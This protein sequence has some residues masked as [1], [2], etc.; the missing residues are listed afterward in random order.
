MIRTTQKGLVS[1]LFVEVTLAVAHRR[2]TPVYYR[3]DPDTYLRY[4]FCYRTLRQHQRQPTA[5]RVR[6]KIH[7]RA[8][9]G[10][11]DAD[12]STRWMRVGNAIRVT[13]SLTRLSIGQPGASVSSSREPDWWLARQWVFRRHG[14]A[15]VVSICQAAIG[16][17]LGFWRTV[18]SMSVTRLHSPTFQSCILCLGPGQNPEP[19]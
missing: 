8:W 5:K 19:C 2:G 14:P 18:L 11:W 16:E 9:T 1:W 6:K 17:K 4:E 7:T 3:H 10:N 13:R 15:G 12:E